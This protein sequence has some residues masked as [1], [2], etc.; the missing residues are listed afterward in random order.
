MPSDEQIVSAHYSKHLESNQHRRYRDCM[1]AVYA[2]TVDALKPRQ[3]LPS[4][5]YETRISAE[6]GN[7][8]AR[9]DSTKDVLLGQVLM[10]N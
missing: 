2:D 10:L 7:G 5:I 8:T 1:H 6:I 9:F 3:S 4:L